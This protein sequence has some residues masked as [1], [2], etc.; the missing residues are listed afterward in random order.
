MTRAIDPP[1]R[2]HATRALAAWM[3][4]SLALSAPAFGAP[5]VERLA[6]YQ[7]DI[8]L[9]AYRDTVAWSAYD[10]ATRQFTL[11]VLER[12]ILRPAPVPTRSVLFDVDVGRS[13]TGGA[14]VVYSRCAHESLRWR[15]VASGCDL[16]AFDPAT[17]RERRI[18]VEP[19]SAEDSHP[20]VSDGR[21]V[22]LRTLRGRDE[23]YVARV[24][25]GRARPVP[26]APPRAANQTYARSAKDLD[27]QR[28][29]FV[30]ARGGQEVHLQHLDGSHWQRV[31]R[32]SG[33]ESGSAFIGLSFD[34]AT[35]GF[36]RAYHGDWNAP[37]SALRFRS[38]RLETAPV[39]HS[40]MDFALAGGRTFWVDAPVGCLARTG[41]DPPGC[42]SVE[43]ADALTFKPFG[44]GWGGPWGA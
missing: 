11:M 1:S 38:G 17:D 12:G 22:F 35:L 15:Q 24:A 44:R 29:A 7:R 13:S 30:L 21:V 6:T 3:L 19:R 27:G 34:G 4:C 8:G 14:L 41:E 10:P 18:P 36:A 28:L 40:L 5:P 16:Y 33:G 31:A 39:P 26:I 2:R 37:G 23:L 9:A 25:G 20:V 32:L 43:R 42:Y